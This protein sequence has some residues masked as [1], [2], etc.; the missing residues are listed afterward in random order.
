MDKIRSMA[1]DP[2]SSN[3][4]ANS[5]AESAPAAQGDES[6]F[7]MMPKLGDDVQPSLFQAGELLAP[8][9]ISKYRKGIAMLHMV[10]SPGERGHTLNSRRVMDAIAALVMIDFKR[11]PRHQV[12][13]LRE[14]DAS[15]MFRV[16]KK[17]LRTMA[18]VASKN[19]GRVE[20]VL[21]LLHNMK[22]QWNVLGEL[23]EVEWN[24]T[25]HFLASYGVGVGPNEGMVCFSIDPRVLNLVLEPRLW[26][27]LN[28]DVQRQLTTETSYVLYQHAWRFIGTTH[29]LTASLP[30]ETWIELLM[31]ESRYVQ[32]TEPG[33][34]KRVVDYSEWKKRYLLPSIDRINNISMLGHTLELVE[35]RAGLKVKRLQFKLLPKTQEK[36]DFPFTWPD[37]I[38]EALKNLGF[39]DGKIADLA[40]GFTLDEV[41]ESLTRYRQAEERKRA[42]GERIAAPT[43]FFYGVLQKTADQLKLDDEAIAA[44]EKAARAEETEQRAREGQARALAE[45]ERRQTKRFVD[46]LRAWPATRSAGLFSAFESSSEFSK[47]KLLVAKGWDNAGQ[48][49][50]SVLKSWARKE[51]PEDYLELLPNPEDRKLEDWLV[52]RID[53]VD[54]AAEH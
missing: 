30:V 5:P 42:Q 13:M 27:S 23:E 40:Q 24:M 2:E 29:K 36:L 9:G 11:R 43:N 33:G 44:I 25:S 48:G 46:T 47:A 4:S 21:E 37:Q 41:V 38:I 3:S 18:G 15:P 28:L 49:A 26:A 52:W 51:R 12:D 34:D 53:Q 50:F 10:P 7:R 54:P 14:L 17:E 8:K 39:E 45:F 31:G 35:S 16:T 19:F 6:N 32:K 22:I 1:T 20:D